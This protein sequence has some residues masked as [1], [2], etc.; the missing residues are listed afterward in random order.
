MDRLVPYSDDEDSDADDIG[1]SLTHQ[2]DNLAENPLDPR[3]RRRGQP[4]T[5]LL[6]P[7]PRLP[8]R[9]ANN[10]P[11]PEPPG[12]QPAHIPRPGS[13]TITQFFRRVEVIQPAEIG[14]QLRRPNVELDEPRIDLLVPESSRLPRRRS[15]DTFQA[16]QQEPDDEQEERPST[17]KRRESSVSLEARIR[18]WPHQ[19]FT[20]S[21]GELYCLACKCALKNDG[22]TIKKF[23]PFL[24]E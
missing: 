23:D 21:G 13:T 14:P 3:Q 2:F 11:A 24:K 6:R 10:D 7:P 4:L 1:P 8:P 18:D 20:I 19:T 16:E 9:P 15:L 12:P 5:H 17:K 22:Y